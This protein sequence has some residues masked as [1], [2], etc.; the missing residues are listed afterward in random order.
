MEKK[1]KVED[2][3][4]AVCL[5]VLLEAGYNLYDIEYAK[6]GP[7]WFLRIYIDKESGIDLDDCEKVSQILDGP[8]DGLDP[9]GHGYY[10]EISSPGVE[11]NLRKPAHFVKAVGEKISLKLFHAWNGK[12]ELLGSLEAVQDDGIRLLLPDVAEK[13]VFFPYQSI[14][15]ANLSVF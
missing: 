15:K 7:D 10:L 3:V 14:A 9:I 13:P 12:K 2:Q 6:E 11:R 1:V 4:E 8:L 5:P